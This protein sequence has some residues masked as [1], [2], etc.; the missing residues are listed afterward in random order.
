MISEMKKNKPQTIEM[1]IEDLIAHDYDVKSLSVY[2]DVPKHAIVE[3]MINALMANDKLLNYVLT[4]ATQS[5][6][7]LSEIS[8]RHGLTPSEFKKIISAVIGPEAWSLFVREIRANHTPVKMIDKAIKKYRTQI[9]YNHNDNN[10]TRVVDNTSAA[11]RKYRCEIKIAT[12]V[13][14]N[15]VLIEMRGK[16]EKIDKAVE[17]IKSHHPDAEVNTVID[18]TENP[19]VKNY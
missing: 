2:L 14:R 19:G 18:K 15:R 12:A 3:M 10:L 4:T 13:N 7:T 16:Q 17:E 1:F 9:T 5:Q 8:W 6:G 11:I